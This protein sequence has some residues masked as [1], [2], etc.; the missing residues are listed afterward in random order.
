[1]LSNLRPTH[2]AL[3]ASFF[4]LGAPLVAARAPQSGP[5]TSP[6]WSF[7]PDAPDRFVGGSVAAAGD[8]N[9]DGFGDLLVGAS[10]YTDPEG[11]EGT[12]M[13][14]LGS[15]TGLE[16]TPS[17]QIFGNQAG[18]ELGESVHGGVDV[19]GDGFDDVVIGVSA[20]SFLPGRVELYLGSAAGLATT[21][22]QI[23]GTGA[24]TGDFGA[25]VRFAGDVDGDGFEDL[26][27]GAPTWS[28]GHSFEGA[29]FLFRGNGHGFDG[30]PAWSLEANKNFA[31][32][33]NAFGVGGDL[34]GDGLADVVVGAEGWSNGQQFEGRITVYH[35]SSSGTP[36]VLAWTKEGNQAGA[37]LGRSVAI[38][39]DTN[40][41]GFDD[42]LV[43]AVGA[44]AGQLAEGRAFLH[45]GSASGVATTPAWIGESNVIGGGFGWAVSGVGDVNGD[46]LA[47]FLVGSDRFDGTGFDEGAAWLYYGAATGA[48]TTPAWFRE[49][50]SSSGQFGFALCGGDFD[51]DGQREWVVGEPFASVPEFHEGGVKAF[52]SCADVDAD[53]IC[54][55]I[56]NCD[57][58]A[59][60]DQADCDGDGFGDVCELVSGSEDL[61]SDAVPDEC[62]SLGTTYCFADGSE[63]PC[64]CGNDASAP[65]EGCANS[66]GRGALLYATGSTSVAAD[67]ARL[68]AIH[69]PPQKAGSVFFGVAKVR[70][71]FGDGSLCAAGSFVRLAT[72]TADVDGVLTQI[73]PVASSGGLIQSG[74]T[75]YFQ[76]WY[77]D[78]LGPC[79]QGHNLSSAL[80]LT[81]VP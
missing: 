67:D 24:S 66:T 64:P 26:L 75:L 12:A 56:D 32:L 4:L 6:T 55:A 77:R 10:R 20:Q 73:Q 29:A 78:A 27:V 57:G 52:T 21:P 30:A 47:D 50:D 35:G 59:N 15:A 34:N 39:G 48:Q 76:C 25:V 42:L 17:W 63:F 8:V 43:G 61:D 37:N 62:E 22:A 74:A 16:P 11:D 9:G 68:T 49:G 36:L 72:Q 81:F 40:G 80:E 65:N 28:N 5:S 54:D 69:L 45:L 23:L 31:T 18:L 53:G 70:I 71:P 79:S 2:A 51:G 60:P 1:M 33:G 14:F 58:I 3:G 46:G 7:Q 19:N 44:S 41:D 13:L 38:A